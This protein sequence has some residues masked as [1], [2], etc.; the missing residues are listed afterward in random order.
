MFPV[1]SRHGT[2][3]S[4]LEN[5]DRQFMLMEQG[6]FK[7]LNLAQRWRRATLRSVAAHLNVPDAPPQIF[8]AEPQ[9]GSKQWSKIAAILSSGVGSAALA[10]QLQRSA[11]QQLDAASYAL[12][13][14]RFELAGAMQQAAPAAQLPDGR[15]LRRPLRSPQSQDALAA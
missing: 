2:W 11:S 4:F 7:I 5:I 14:L 1:G 3:I 10:S 6:L 13:I 12:D 9:G 15:P 8:L